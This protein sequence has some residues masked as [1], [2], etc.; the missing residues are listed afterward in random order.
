MKKF[1]T[2]LAAAAVTVGAF[3]AAPRFVVENNAAPATLTTKAA[4]AEVRNIEVA[5]GNH[6]VVKSA[7]KAPIGGGPSIDKLEGEYGQYYYNMVQGDNAGNQGPYIAAIVEGDAANT[8]DVYGFF[9]GATRDGYQNKVTGTYDQAKGVLTIKNGTSIG[10][11]QFSDG[12]AELYIY[13]QDWDTYKILDKDIEFKYTPATHSLNFEAANDGQ[14]FTENLIICTNANASVGQAIKT[15]MAFP[16][17]MNLF[18][19]NGTMSL[20]FNTSNGASPSQSLVYYE[21][22]D[23]SL[24]VSNIQGL[25]YDV[26]VEMTVDKAAKTA[27]LIDQSLTLD[28]GGDFGERTCYFGVAQ[29]QS[30]YTNVTFAGQTTN[31]ESGV[32]TVLSTPKYLLIDDEGVGFNVSN[33]TIELFDVALFDATAIENVTVDFDENAPVEY[34]NLQGVRVENPAN[35]L[36][37]KR[38]GNK[39]AKV[40]L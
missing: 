14:S 33:A 7:V 22:F 3:A 40:I 37:I 4:K 32:S 8:L 1:Y 12:P 15:G 11:V 35:G 29:G 9:L 39:V 27:S 5:V 24:F 23:N 18:A 2:L 34:F 20:T 30:L 31:D 21:A 13:L 16:V 6:K 38:Q 19:V 25:G 17:T 10:T 36:Y 28:L 26:M